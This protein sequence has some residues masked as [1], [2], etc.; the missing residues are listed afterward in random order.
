MKINVFAKPFTAIFIGGGIGGFLLTV[1][2]G[3]MK[4]MVVPPKST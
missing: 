4:W 1:I 3:V 2:A